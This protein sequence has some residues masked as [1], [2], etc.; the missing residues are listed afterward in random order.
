LRGRGIR[1]KKNSFI[2]SIRASDRDIIR[3]IDFKKKKN[4]PKATSAAAFLLLATT[5]LVVAS[6]S[7][8][9]AALA[10]RSGTGDGDFIDPTTGLR[11]PRAPAVVSGDNIYI[12]WWTNNTENGNEEVMFRASTDG[13][14]TFSNTTN[15]SNT[16]DA[17]SI[18]AEIAAEGETVIVTWWERNQT[19]D[20]PL[21]RVSN[22]AGETFGPLMMLAA[23]GTLGSGEAEPVGGGGGEGEEEE[24]EEPSPE[25]VIEEAI[26]G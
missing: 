24:E 19:S 2:H 7:T 12:A 20:V 23:N 6:V 14:A 1:W 3:N 13:G 5:L 11:S 26:G 10:S 18:D 8:P 9:L 16:T 25:G 15:L 17:D 4:N 22:D 21:A